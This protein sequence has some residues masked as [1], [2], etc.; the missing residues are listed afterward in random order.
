MEDNEKEVIDETIEETQE[1]VTEVEETEDD[2]DNSNIPSLEDYEALK[3]KAE[4]LEAQKEHWRKKASIEAKPLQTNKTDG[5]SEEQ[6]LKMAK[7][8]SSI[9]NEDLEVLKTIVGDSIA[10]KVDN[11]LFKAYKEAKEKKKRSEAS[12]LKPST[13]SFVYDK[14]NPNSPE[15][16]AEEHRKLVE[17]MMS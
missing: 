12:S 4:T 6:L 16:S 5:I 11:P 8:A 10:D 1:E 13:P 14:K 15:L 7:I 2:E 9:D 3:K 17:K